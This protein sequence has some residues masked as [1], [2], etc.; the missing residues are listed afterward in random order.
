MAI[1]KGRQTNILQER[2]SQ[3]DLY[4]SAPY[5]FQNSGDVAIDTNG[6]GNIIDFAEE[7]TSTKDV[8][9]DEITINNKS[10]SDLWV[11]PNQRQDWKRL[12]RAGTIVPLSEF[13]GIRSVRYSKE[14]SSV[15]IAQY[16]IQITVKRSPL[17]SNEQVRRQNAMPT[18][19]K[20]IHNKLGI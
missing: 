15:T 14:D 6:G 10:G 3:I 1:L 18:L 12:I 5:S 8:P 20:M 19:M 16:E 17:T 9:F 4:G 2:Q 11:Y 7:S 13:K